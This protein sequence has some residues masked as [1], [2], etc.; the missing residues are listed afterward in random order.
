MSRKS[1]KIEKLMDEGTELSQI[2]RENPDLIDGL[3]DLVPKRVK[4]QAATQPA[5]GSGPSQRT[6][7]KMDELAGL[8]PRS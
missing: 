6:P 5:R 2:I 1:K 4:R 7:M 8:A 3:D